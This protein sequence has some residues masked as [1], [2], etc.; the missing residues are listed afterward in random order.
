MALVLPNPVQ[1]LEAAPADS[2][3]YRQRSDS[4]VEAFMRRSIVN[5]WFQILALLCFGPISGI[6]AFP[7]LETQQP[8]GPEVWRPGDGK[9]P[10]WLE[11]TSKRLEKAKN[12]NQSG[13]EI[14]FIHSRASEL[15]ERAKSSRENYFRFDRFI[16]AANA[17]LE[18]S[19][20]ILWSRKLE[21]VPQEQDYWG[22]GLF[23]PG[24]Y[25]RVRQAEFFASLIGEKNTEQYVTWSKSFYQQARGAYDA[26]EYQRAKLL[27]DASYSIVFALECI[28]QATVEMPDTPIIK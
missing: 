6:E 26:R 22:A 12:A 27:A 5:R 24:C 28:A 16:A 1:E 7:A 9:W 18:A 13:P 21:R 19:D 2:W 15:L 14:E 10:D 3:I 17:M 4:T 20:R 23:L 8:K 11:V 25:F